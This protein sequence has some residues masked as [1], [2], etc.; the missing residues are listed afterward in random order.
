MKKY[1]VDLKSSWKDI[2]VGDWEKIKVIES[3]IELI[4]I[5]TDKT[6]DEVKELP[7]KVMASIIE[8]LDFIH[9]SPLLDG[10]ERV[11]ERIK[12]D[13]K[14]KLNKDIN[15]WSTIRFINSCELSKSSEDIERNLP[16]IFSNVCDKYTKQKTWYGRTK[17]VQVP[18]NDRDLLEEAD[19]IREHMDIGTVFTYVS[20]FLTILEHTQDVGEPCS[21]WVNLETNRMKRLIRKLNN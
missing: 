10:N 12:D 6:T 18:F 21:E 4:S 13:T 8:E 16:V 1:S 3:D 19:Y 2:T 17:W 11:S 20:F 14:W 7:V 15:N 9:E 5:L